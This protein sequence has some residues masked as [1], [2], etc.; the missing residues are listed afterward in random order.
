MLTITDKERREVYI[1]SVKVFLRNTFGSYLLSWG[2][3][4]SKT[5]QGFYGIQ[6]I[7][8]TINKNA[9]LG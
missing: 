9:Q 7:G 3:G 8:P 5:V 1:L 2:K 6:K 4:I